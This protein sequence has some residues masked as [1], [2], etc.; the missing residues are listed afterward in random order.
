MR[1]SRGFT[2]V[3]VMVALLLGTIGLLGTLAVQQAVIS[4]SRAANDAAVAMR[5]ASQ[6][7]EEFNSYLTTNDPNLPVIPPAL[8]NVDQLADYITAN[9]QD[10]SPAQFVNAEGVPGAQSVANRWIR[11]WRV[12]NLGTGLPYVISVVVTYA[13]DTGDPRTVRLD[14]ERRKSW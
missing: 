12:V 2:L 4:A 3:E 5:L 6:K 13:A 8:P 7:T 9:G 1:R 10:W 11:R 14:V